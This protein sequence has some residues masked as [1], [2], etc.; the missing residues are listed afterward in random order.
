MRIHLYLIGAKW[1]LQE[2]V[3]Q[4][5]AIYTIYI[6]ICTHSFCHPLFVCIQ[7]QPELLPTRA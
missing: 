5:F 7:N 3:Q 4:N 2:M 6:L 1:V